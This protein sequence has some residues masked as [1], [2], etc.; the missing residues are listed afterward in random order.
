MVLADK[1]YRHHSAQR[2]MHDAGGGGAASGCSCWEQRAEELIIHLA[3]VGR[4]INIYATSGSSANGRC[5]WDCIA[6]HRVGLQ[7]RTRLTTMCCKVCTS[8]LLA[9]VTHRSLWE[10]LTDVRKS[11]GWDSFSWVLKISCVTLLEFQDKKKIYL[12]TQTPD[13]TH[14]QSPPLLQNA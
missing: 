4:L 9:A 10:L 14:S 1:I 7:F 5:R 6:V 12:L 2:M 13:I 8:C 11:L 3:A